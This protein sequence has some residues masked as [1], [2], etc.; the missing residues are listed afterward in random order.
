MATTTAMAAALGLH[1]CAADVTAGSLSLSYRSGPRAV[2]LTEIRLV[3]SAA[4]DYSRIDAVHRLVEQAGRG[5]W[6]SVARGPAWRGSRLPD[7]PTPPGR[8]PWPG[9]LGEA[10]LRPP[11][12]PLAS[13]PSHPADLRRPR[14]AA[15][16]RQ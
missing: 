4:L 2:P 11:P 9:G 6:T 10:E 7:R 3:R 5:P 1:G 8:S 16:P 13:L 14:P 12:H 15:P